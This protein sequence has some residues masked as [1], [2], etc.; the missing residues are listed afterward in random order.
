MYK[1][2]ITVVSL[3]N[4]VYNIK[5][6]YKGQFIMEYIFIQIFYTH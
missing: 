5:D 2:K 6:N 1:T 4:N 3:K